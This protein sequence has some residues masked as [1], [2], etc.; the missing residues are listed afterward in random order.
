MAKPK[1]SI[2]YTDEDLKD[3]MLQSLFADSNFRNSFKDDME[4]CMRCWDILQNDKE[5]YKKYKEVINMKI[6]GMEEE[7]ITG[8]VFNNVPTKADRSGSLDIAPGY[9]K[10]AELQNARFKWIC[11]TNI[12]WYFQS[13]DQWQRTTFL[14][15]YTT[16]H[17]WNICQC[18]I[19]C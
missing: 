15:K 12:N 2:F 8:R 13:V 11:N 6:S 14:C 18:V 3:I 17:W 10:L 9:L 7:V 4:S 5:F 16:N 19:E 1:K